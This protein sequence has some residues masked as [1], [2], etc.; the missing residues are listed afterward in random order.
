MGAVTQP[1]RQRA[2]QSLGCDRSCQ[3]GGGK[4]GRKAGTDLKVQSGSQLLGVPS[5]QWTQESI[6]GMLP[7][8]RKHMIRAGCHFRG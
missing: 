7:G 6:R 1:C 5:L 2:A 8:V 4:A 3:V